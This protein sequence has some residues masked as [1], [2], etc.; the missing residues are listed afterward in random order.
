MYSKFDQ[1]SLV[2]LGK[3]HFRLNKI[4]DSVKSKA[5]KNLVLCSSLNPEPDLAYENLEY[6]LGQAIVSLIIIT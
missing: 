5:L 1:T 2:W 3:G 6:S 4:V